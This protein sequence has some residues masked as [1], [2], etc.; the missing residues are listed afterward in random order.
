MLERDASG[1]TLEIVS[2]ERRWS[3]YYV[4]CRQFVALGGELRCALATLNASD[5]EGELGGRRI[6]QFRSQFRALNESLDVFFGYASFA[7]S[8]GANALDDY[9][10]SEGFLAFEL[11]AP[12]GPDAAL[13]DVSFLVVGVRS[14]P[15]GYFFVAEDGFA[16]AACSAACAAC[17]GSA[18]NCAFATSGPTLETRDALIQVGALQ[19][20]QT[21]D[22]ICLPQQQKTGFYFG[23]WRFRRP[24]A[25]LP[26]LYVG[27][28]QLRAQKGYKQ[29]NFYAEVNK[30]SCESFS[31]IV[32]CVQ[33]QYEV[34]TEFQF[35]A[36]REDLVDLEVAPVKGQRPDTQL[37]YQR[38]R[39][40]EPT[41]FVGVFLRGIHQNDFQNVIVQFYQVL[42]FN[43]SGFVLEYSRD[44]YNFDNLFYL[45]VKQS[46][47][48]TFPLS[49]HRTFR[50][51][52]AEL[53]TRANL[54]Q[55]PAVFFLNQIYSGS[56]ILLTNPHQRLSDPGLP[57][58]FH[59]QTDQALNLHPVAFLVLQI[60]FPQCP[61]SSLNLPAAAQCV[62]VRNCP[63]GLYP[64]TDPVSTQSYCLTCPTHCVNCSSA[65]DCHQC[66][67]P[68]RSPA[69]L[70]ECTPH[71]YPDG[72]DCLGNTRTQYCACAT[73]NGPSSVPRSILRRSEFIS[74]CGCNCTSPGRSK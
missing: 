44:N 63:P 18:E 57:L 14:C 53:P 31:F 20:E 11:S 7:L 55:A 35:I 4:A 46:T 49:E 10:L 6:A 28:R 12:A 22:D 1:F 62:F 71:Q 52:D 56:E 38:F 39:S 43:A 47:F 40:V 41:Q 19:I 67:S 25:A 3:G 64:H 54:Y 32:V 24:F 33:G 59:I 23:T 13:G 45:R 5:A 8:A 61:R 37:L 51:P 65:L 36:L 66:A 72:P 2:N 27:L 34:G 68:T 16:C 15:E 69:A 60:G 58:A 73:S 70:C 50:A 26:T 9:Y 42:Q 30:V 29:I 74:L 17:S 48:A 21:T